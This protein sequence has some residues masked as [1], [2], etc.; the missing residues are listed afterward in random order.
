[1]GELFKT[2]TYNLIFE[3]YIRPFITIACQQHRVTY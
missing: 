2:H 1:M 3:C